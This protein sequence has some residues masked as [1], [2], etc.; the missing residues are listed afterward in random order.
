MVSLLSTLVMY[1]RGFLWS[2]V[3]M[4]KMDIINI[5]VDFSTAILLFRQY[6]FNRNNIILISK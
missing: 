2:L 4:I 6:Q 5:S 3:I 1:S